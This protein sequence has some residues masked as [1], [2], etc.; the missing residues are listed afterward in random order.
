M[1]ELSFHLCWC[2]FGGGGKKLL[3]T[4]Y[5]SLSGQCCLKKLQVRSSGKFLSRGPPYNDSKAGQITTSRPTG[6]EVAGNASW[7]QVA[8]MQGFPTCPRT[9]GELHIAGVGQ[10]VHGCFYQ[11]CKIPSPWCDSRI[12]SALPVFLPPCLQNK[13]RYYLPHNKP[14]LVV[15]AAVSSVW[16]VL[17]I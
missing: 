2:Y 16:T 4:E 10:E 6:E 3:W 8:Q 9:H 7:K 13:R 5:L 14:R 11:G 15:V 1:I 17:E 12:H